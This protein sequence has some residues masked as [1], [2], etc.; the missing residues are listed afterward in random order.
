MP[1]ALG[2]ADG[3][4]VAVAG[5]EADL[6]LGVLPDADQRE[7][8]LLELGAGGGE[9]GPELGALEKRPSQDVLEALDA[10]GDGGLRDVHPAGRL[11]EAAR[12]GDH[13][14]R[15][16]ERDVHAVRI[17]GPAPAHPPGSYLSKISIGV[18][19]KFR[20]WG[21]LNL[22]T[23]TVP[24][25]SR[26]SR[27]CIAPAVTQRKK[28]HEGTCQEARRQEGRSRQEARREEAGRQEEVSYASLCS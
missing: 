8:V 6:A 1:E 11:D 19:G 2:S 20:L 10:G 13:Q 14:E 5:G 26:V 23:L 3:Q 27:A 16:C 12:L 25:A 17:L 22:T 15:S 18:S 7:G 28:H 21:D 24:G 9:L 4:M